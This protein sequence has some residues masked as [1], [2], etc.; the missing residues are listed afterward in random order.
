MME[1]MKEC[2]SFPPAFNNSMGHSSGPVAFLGFIFFRTAPT[3]SGEIGLLRARGGPV[4]MGQIRGQLRIQD[5]L[6][7]SLSLFF[8]LFSLSLYIYV[9][10]FLSRAS[11]SA[12]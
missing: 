4:N 1:A 10:V 7:P 6:Y 3:S 5:E 12:T 9:Y 11:A 8:L 2:T